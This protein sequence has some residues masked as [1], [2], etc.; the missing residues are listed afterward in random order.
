MVIKRTCKMGCL[1]WALKN[2][3]LEHKSEF[4]MMGVKSFTAKVVSLSVPILFFSFL[5]LSHLPPSRYYI[6]L[7]ANWSQVLSDLNQ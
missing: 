6:S 1:L 4:G 7:L 5:F 3:N 2:E